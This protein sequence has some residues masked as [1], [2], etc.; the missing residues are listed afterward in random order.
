VSF[1]AAQRRQLV[2]AVRAGQTLCCPVCA[3]PLTSHPIEP[4]S[5][6]PYVRRRVLVICPGCRRSATLD[7]KV[8]EPR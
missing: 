7:V 4:R 6:L 3:E 8:D 2:A 1:D 5:D